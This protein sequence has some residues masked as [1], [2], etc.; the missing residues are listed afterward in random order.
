MDFSKCHVQVKGRYIVSCL[1]VA[2]GCIQLT[3]ID[4]PHIMF[5]KT[6]CAQKHSQ[7]PTWNL[8]MKN[9][10]CI[11]KMSLSFDNNDKVTNMFKFQNV[12]I[13][14]S[15]SAFPTQL[16]SCSHRKKPPKTLHLCTSHVAAAQVERSGC[17]I[18]GDAVGCAVCEQG[19]IFQQRLACYEV[20]SRLPGG[21]KLWS[22]SQQR[23]TKNKGIP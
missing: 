16:L 11:D 6:N 8:K 18:Q 9:L 22:K 14:S 15:F 17:P 21:G 10:T 23:H 20:T 1:V 2:T 19:S 7:Q 3:F 13:N 5:L 12:P 4:F